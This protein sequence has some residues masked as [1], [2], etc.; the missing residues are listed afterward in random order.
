MDLI[1]IKRKK[2]HIYRNYQQLILFQE[3]LNTQVTSFS[4]VQYK[5]KN[6]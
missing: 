3:Q 1:A 4:D 6:Y 2:K 5:S